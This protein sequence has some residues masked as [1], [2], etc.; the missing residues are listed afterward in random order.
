[1]HSQPMLRN[2]YA[3]GFAAA[4]AYPKG[5]CCGACLREGP[6]TVELQ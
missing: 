6:S 2:A 4:V 1:M 5:L 3:K